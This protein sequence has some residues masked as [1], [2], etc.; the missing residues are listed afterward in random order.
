MQ[1]A[2]QAGVCVFSNTLAIHLGIWETCSHI[3]SKGQALLWLFWAQAQAWASGLQTSQGTGSRYGPAPPS[4]SARLAWAPWVTGRKF[5]SSWS[6]LR[7][8]KG[9]T[10]A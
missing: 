1:I 10:M 5:M 3:F 4:A 7:F 9:G 2:L 6:W 8:A